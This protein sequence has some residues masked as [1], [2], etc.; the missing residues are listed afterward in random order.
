M[1]WQLSI[2][3]KLNL[4]DKTPKV[5][6][7][8]TGILFSASF[9]SFLDEKAVSYLVTDKVPEMLSAHGTMPV[10][11]ILTNIKDVPAFI[12]NKFQHRQFTHADIPLN[13]DIASVLKGLSAEYLIQLLNYVYYTDKHQV[14]TKYN[15]ESLLSF[16]KSHYAISVVSSLIEQITLLLQ[17]VPQFDTILQSPYSQ[18]K[19]V[20]F[21]YRS[22][23]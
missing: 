11:V 14:I 1:Q 4:E 22:D 18:N 2:Y 23:F 16:A 19:S 12:T 21:F 13:G 20:Q 8:H 5:I 10:F 9:L 3:T 15:I 17:T 7:D 6:S